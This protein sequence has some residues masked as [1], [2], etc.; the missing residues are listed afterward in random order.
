MIRTRHISFACAAL[1]VALIG[2][3]VAA[4]AE[5]TELPEYAYD[6]VAEI[7][8]VTT[9]QTECEGAKVNDRRLQR[10]MT[11]FVGRLAGDGFDPV[12]SVQ[13][14]DTEVGLAEIAKR[15]VALRE[16]HGVAPEGFE[17]L[18][19]AIRAE[20]KINKNLARIVKFP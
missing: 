11:D 10:A 15:E 4:L 2:L 19:A 18:C 9:A 6:S 13:F 8:M 7:S 17:A 5:I 12:A 14:M 3:P 16:R 1:A 20:T